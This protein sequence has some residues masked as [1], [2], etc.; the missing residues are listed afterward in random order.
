MSDPVTDNYGLVLPTVGGDTDLWGGVQNNG[1]FGPI[2]AILGANLPV[3]I[4][5]TDVNLSNAQF[6]NAIFVLSGALTG[7]RSLIVPLSTNSLTLACGGRFVVVNNTTGNFSVTVKTAASGSTG[8][9]VPQGFA[10]FLYSDKTNV[11]YAT[12]GLPGFAAAVSGNPNGQLA[13]TAGSATTNAQ[14]AWDYTNGI[15]YVCTTTGNAAAAVW[16]APQVVVPR[17][18]DMPVNLGL[19]VTHTGGNLLNLAI[20]TA[21]GADATLLNPIIVPFQTVSGVNTTG[22]PTTVN[23]TSAL[24]MTTS[25]IGASMGAAN[26]TPFRVWFALFNNAG[27]AVPAMR[28]CST[29]TGV[30]GVAES[31][32]DSTVSIDASATSAGVWYTPNGTT[33]ANCAYRLIGYCEYVTGN[34]LA[35]AGTYSADPSNVV[36]FGPGIKKPGD[37]VQTSVGTNSSIF[38]TTSSVFVPTNL[39]GS[40]QPTSSI[41]LVR[42]QAQGALSCTGGVITAI[43]QLYRTSVANMIGNQALNFQ[44]PPSGFGTGSTATNFALDKPQS[45]SALTYGVAV[46]GG[47]ASINY[48]GTPAPTATTSNIVLDEIMG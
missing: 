17:G 29:A 45:T 7:N 30:Q 19:T 14:F 39:T 9:T 34:T 35:T 5:A 38:T 32:V 6:Q 12:N 15:L 46:K 4:N 48:S 3:T 22:K 42:A 31:G 8:V 2:D 11:G 21:A 1:I 43:A 25:A 13:G 23:I 41:N 26:A 44:N 36:L 20:T 47:G 18:F 33:L 28:V 27:V 16:T 40:I 24:S 37:V 10:A